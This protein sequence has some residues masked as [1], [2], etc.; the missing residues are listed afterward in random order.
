MAHHVA[1]IGAGIVG[2]ACALELLRDGHQVT[3]VEPGEPGGEQAASYGNGTLLNPSSVVPMSA[4]GLWRK[5]PGY[6]ADPLGPLTIPWSYLPRLLPWL[7][8]F[9]Q[10]GATPE[11][12][13]AIGRALQPLLA[14]APARHRALA[15]EA[16]VG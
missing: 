8:R 2:A 3:I 11:K 10:A 13:A 16:R 5:V 9:V 6:L 15:E 4:P 12:V 7:L 1:I 14:D